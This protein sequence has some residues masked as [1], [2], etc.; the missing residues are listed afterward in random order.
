M[1]WWNRNRITSINIPLQKGENRGPTMR[2]LSHNYTGVTLL[3]TLV[4]HCWSTSWA[5]FRITALAWAGSL[6]SCSLQSLALPRRGFLLDPY[7]LCPYLKRTGEKA[8]L[9]AVQ[10]P[11]RR[12]NCLWLNWRTQTFTHTCGFFDNTASSKICLVSDL[13]APR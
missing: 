9:G 10:L 6:L 2:S 13:F 5:A 7:S 4:L 11:P 3:N 12:L 1:Q 8:L